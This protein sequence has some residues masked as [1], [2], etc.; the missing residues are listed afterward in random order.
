MFFER[1]I[2]CSQKLIIL[3]LIQL[4]FINTMNS[5]QPLQWT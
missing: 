2:L 1:S 5:Q 4:S 3:Q